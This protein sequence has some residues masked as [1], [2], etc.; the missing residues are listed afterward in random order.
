MSW[1][2]APGEVGVE[3]DADLVGCETWDV[4]VDPE[5]E[6]SKNDILISKKQAYLNKYHSF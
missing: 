6:L 2:E 5:E 4:F 1:F 3:L